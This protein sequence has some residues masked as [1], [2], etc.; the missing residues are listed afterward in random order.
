MHSICMLMFDIN[1]SSDNPISHLYFSFFL[2]L[3]IINFAHY[4]A[5]ITLTNFSSILA[6]DLDRHLVM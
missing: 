6:I 1:I 5:K 2:R 3:E 4:L